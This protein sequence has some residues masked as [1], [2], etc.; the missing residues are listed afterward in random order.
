MSHP[1]FEQV[2]IPEKIEIVPTAG[3]IGQLTPL[4]TGWRHPIAGMT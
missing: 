3:P 4:E 1:Y 2:D